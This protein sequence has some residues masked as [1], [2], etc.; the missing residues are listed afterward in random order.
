MK[1]APLDMRMDRT[2]TLTAYDVVNGWS[3]EELRRI[4]FE[5]GEERYAPL[6][7]AAIER[8]RE[9]KPI[10]TT[11]ELV[12]IIKGAMPAK[13]LREK[14]HPAKRSFQAIRCV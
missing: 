10:E 2:Q 3:R 11:G 9:K 12:E 14:Q 8:E 5:Y 4:L 7:A 13:A 6:I 1:D